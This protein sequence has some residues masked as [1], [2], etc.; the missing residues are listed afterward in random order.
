MY[1]SIYIFTAPRSKL[2][3]FIEVKD[4]DLATQK[5]LLCVQ[6]QYI[7]ETVHDHWVMGFMRGR[8]ST[9]QRPDRKF[10]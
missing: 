10:Y 2:I 4:I 1:I 5:V 6:Q 8:R 9:S 7:K 3:T